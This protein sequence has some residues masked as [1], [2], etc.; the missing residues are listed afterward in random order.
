MLIKSSSHFEEK[1][2]RRSPRASDR[3]GRGVSDGG[4][5]KTNTIITISSVLK[6]FECIQGNTV[7]SLYTSFSD[8]EVTLPSI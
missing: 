2:R 8:T 7:N 5:E 4:F 1:E 6:V 3:G